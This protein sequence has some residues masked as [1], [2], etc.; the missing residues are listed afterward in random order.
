ME[1]KKNNKTNT[2]KNEEE[3]D[4]LQRKITMHG[5]QGFVR[6]I[7]LSVYCTWKVTKPNKYLKWN[8]NSLFYYL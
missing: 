4:Y 1:W 7:H 3:E 8:G 5:H 6:M 2:K